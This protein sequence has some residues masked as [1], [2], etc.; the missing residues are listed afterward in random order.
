MA[1]LIFPHDN[2][3]MQELLTLYLDLPFNR[4][5]GLQ[6]SRYTQD[7]LTLTLAM[8]PDFIGNRFKQI[9]HGGIISAAIDAAGGLMFL[10]KS[11]E[12]MS[13]CSA[14][15]KTAKLSHSSTIDLRVDYLRPGAGNQFTLHTKILRQGSHIT[16]THTEFLNEK[17]DLLATGTGAYFMK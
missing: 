3:D 8:K 6:C 14:E 10:L 15:E 4:F 2:D 17:D 16:V 11:I 5:L 9:L 7:Q 12:K 1:E 13:T